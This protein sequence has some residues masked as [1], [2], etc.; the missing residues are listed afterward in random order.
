MTSLNEITERGK[1]EKSHV[2]P[3]YVSPPLAD[4]CLSTTGLRNGGKNE[5]S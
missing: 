5:L 3:S 4:R 2:L 1:R